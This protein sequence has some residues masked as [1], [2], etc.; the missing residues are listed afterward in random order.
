[1]FTREY[2]GRGSNRASTLCKSASVEIIYSE[3]AL[4]D[5]AGG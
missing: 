4:L 2:N 5:G 1:M 3:D